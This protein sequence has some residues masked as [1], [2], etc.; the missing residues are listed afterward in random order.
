MAGIP[1]RIA[2][3]VISTEAVRGTA[4]RRN[5][6][7]L[8]AGFLRSPRST[9]PTGDRVCRPAPRRWRPGEG[10]PG[11]D[12][13]LPAVNHAASSKGGRNERYGYRRERAAQGRPALP[14]RARQLRRRHRRRQRSGARLRQEPGGAWPHPL[15]RQAGGRG[16]PGVHGGRPGR[17]PAD[18]RAVQAARIQALR[19]PGARDDQGPLRRRDGRG[20][21][22]CDPCRGGRPRPGGRGRLRGARPGGG[23]AGGARAGGAAG[24]RFVGRQH[25]SEH[26]RRR[27]HG[28]GQGARRAFGDPRVPHEPTGDGPDGRAR[29]AGGVERADGPADRPHRDP[30]AASDPR[31]PRHVPRAGAAPGAGHRPRRGRRG[32]GSRPMSSRR[33][34]SPAGTR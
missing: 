2:P 22:R 18:A 28:P 12:G 15:D 27:R 8:N 6:H 33:S 30:G 13:P 21:R 14:R 20:L 25:R 26:P 23:H 24:P 9:E 34:S 1:F 10:A 11:V 17:R 7:P 16:E 32:S 29:G 19:L 5:L 31:R 4:E 3:T